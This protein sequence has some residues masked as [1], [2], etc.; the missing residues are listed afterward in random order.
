[1][2]LRNI[3]GSK[4]FVSSHPLVFCD[5]NAEANKGSW[6]SVFNRPQPLYLEIGMGR[7]RFI[8]SSATANPNINYLGLELRESVLLQALERI[9][10]TPD[11]LR[12]LW[13]NAATLDSV[14]A[15]GEISRIYLNFSDPWPKSRHA[16]RRLTAPGFLQL[17]TEILAPEGDIFF[18]TDNMDL[19]YWSRENFLADNFEIREE[20]EDLPLFEDTVITEYEA[21]YRKKGLPIFFLHAAKKR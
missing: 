19:F 10:T 5:A 8:I 16:K 6:Q 15:I 17:Y 20:S 21:R 13:L 7:G 2:R 12:L 3:P 9:K 14:F 18:R 1:M 4:Q 11:N